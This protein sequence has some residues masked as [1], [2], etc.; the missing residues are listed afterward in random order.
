VEISANVMSTVARQSAI[1]RRVAGGEIQE[2][3]FFARHRA[4]TVANSQF[5]R[6]S[7]VPSIPLNAK[8]ILGNL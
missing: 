7:P 8:A 3:L 2:K 6:L 4:R 1:H 5:S